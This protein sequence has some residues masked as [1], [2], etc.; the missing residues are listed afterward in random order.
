MPLRSASARPLK[1]R[2][3]HQNFDHINEILLAWHMNQTPGSQRER[4]RERCYKPFN[5]PQLE[6]W[7][8]QKNASNGGGTDSQPNKEL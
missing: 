3:I 6:D 8:E 5:A 2:L 7:L 4:E 1:M